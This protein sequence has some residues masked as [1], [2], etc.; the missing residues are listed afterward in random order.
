MM[1]GAWID[2]GG[3]PVSFLKK[4]PSRISIPCPLVPV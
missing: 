3:M 4:Y 2:G 1:D